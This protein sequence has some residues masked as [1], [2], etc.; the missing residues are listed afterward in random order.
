[1]WQ[2]AA[3]VVAQVGY[4]G[5][6]RW[7]TV[8]ARFNGAGAQLEAGAGAGCLRSGRRRW[9]RRRTSRRAAGGGTGVGRALGG[10][11]VRRG[12]GPGGRRRRWEAED[13]CEARATGEHEGRRWSYS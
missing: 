6:R 7:A 9:K 8:A 1:M 5:Q 2:W 3:K 13:G 12:A 11:G 10:A 4:R